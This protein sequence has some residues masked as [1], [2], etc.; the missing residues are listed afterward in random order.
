MKKNYGEILDIE[1]LEGEEWAPIEGYG[2]DYWVSTFGRVKSFKRYKEGKILKQTKSKGYYQINFSKNNISK[3][4][5]VHRLVAEVFLPNLN[6]FPQVNHKDENKTNNHID[7]LEW[8][9][10]KYNNNY[11]NKLK[12]TSIK[13]KCKETGEI[14]YSIREVSRQLNINRNTI[15]KS[16]KDGK[17]HAGYTFEKIE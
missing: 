10:A 1:D 11:G 12:N 9:T 17:P 8:C 16:L 15:S 5:N 13:I 6:N 3:R 14:F 2:G 7:N 4:K